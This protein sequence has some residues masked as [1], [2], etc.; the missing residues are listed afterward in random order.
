MKKIMIAAM[1][2]LSTS[3]VFA[4]D[5][6]ALKA[7]TKTKN[8]ADAA[9]LVKNT[10]AQ[11]ADASEKAKAYEHLTKLA[12]EKFDKENA[13]QAQNMQAQLTKQKEQPY[14]T[15]GFYQAAYNATMDGLECLKYDAMPNAKGK[16]RKKYTSSLTPLIS[17]A[18]M[19]LVTAGNY[20]AQNGNQDG[21]LKY[22][23]TFLD[24]DDNPAFAASKQSEAQFIGQVAYY[25][26]QYANQANQYDRAMKYA[27]IAMQDKDMKK[28]AEAFKYAMAQRGLKTKEDSVKYTATL[29]TAYDNDP[30]NE[31]I[32]GTL[33]NMYTGLEMGAELDALLA[34]KLAKEPKN[35]TAWA[36]KGQTLLN[37]NAKAENPNWDE[38]INAFK[39]AINIDATNP[40]VLTYLGFAIN[41]KAAQ[42][43]GDLAAQKK[44][45]EESMGYLE[46]A[47]EI[48][49]TR[50]KANWVYPLYQC[51]YV[52][53]KA[54]D[55]RTKEL[56][57]ILKQ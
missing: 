39:E 33:C 37:R 56:E 4:G 16:V 15:I 8:Y 23:G 55:P 57:K 27:E 35:F 30:S 11:L 40:V 48:D 49:P 18:R 53:Y 41:A 5:S 36:L 29:K 17:N 2:M 50:E 34:E 20:Y 43:N 7:I 19:Q 9:Q 26:A 24:T 42:I 52:I 31:M 47:K 10:L 45:Y 51:Y 13:I 6:D 12:L 1:M 22:W 28:Q 54:T 21:V 14:D 25:T 38:C 44:L 32:F 3:A 46:K